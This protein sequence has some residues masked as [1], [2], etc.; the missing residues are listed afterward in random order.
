[1]STAPSRTPQPSGHV[2]VATIAHAGR[3]WETWLEFED[4][5]RRPTSHRARFRFEPP[6]GDD[7]VKSAFTTYL[8]VEE[9]YDAAVAKARSFDDRVLQGMLRSTL[10][11]PGET[12]PTGV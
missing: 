11:D 12:P 3:I 7:A 2:H 1:M 4:D 5:P 6:S 10:P 8:I 9:S